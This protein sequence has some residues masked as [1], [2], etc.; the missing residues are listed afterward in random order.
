MVVFEAEV[1]EKPKSQIGVLKELY[2]RL[3]EVL[4]DCPS[5]C[6]RCRRHF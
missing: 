6:Y 4:R 1:L 2:N 5:Q 3:A